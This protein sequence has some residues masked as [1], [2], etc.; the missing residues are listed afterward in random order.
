MPAGET[1][2]TV[3]DLTPGSWVIMSTG[4]PTPEPRTLTVTESEGT[5]TVTIDPVAG[6]VA[7]VQEYA[8]ILPETIPAGPQVWSVENIGTQPHFVEVISGA[9]WHDRAGHHGGPRH[10]RSSRRGAG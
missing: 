9:G 2:R 10:G 1:M 7:Q 5:P 6:V 8:I 3:V 4:N